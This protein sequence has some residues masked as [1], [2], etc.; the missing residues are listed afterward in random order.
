VGKVVVVQELTARRREDESEVVRLAREQLAA[1]DDDRGQL[2]VVVGESRRDLARR[3]HEPSGRVQDQLDRLAPWCL[4]NDPED[5][6]GVVDVDVLDEW[7]SRRATLIP[8]G[9]SG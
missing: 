7:G 4:V 3:D 2:P 6:L 8:A 5:A 9:G 1:E